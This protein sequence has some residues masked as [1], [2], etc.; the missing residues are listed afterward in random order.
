[1][2]RMA[3]HRLPRGAP[4]TA[5]YGSYRDSESYRRSNRQRADESRP[6]WPLTDRDLPGRLAREGVRHG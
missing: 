4:M 1:M 6:V 2:P 3:H 5:P